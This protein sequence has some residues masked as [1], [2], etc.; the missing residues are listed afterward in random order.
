MNH[1]LSGPARGSSLSIATEADGT[2]L[3]SHRDVI[4]VR[5]LGSIVRTHRRAPESKVDGPSGA[6]ADRESRGLLVTPIVDVGAVSYLGKEMLFLDEVRGGVRN[7]EE[8]QLRYGAPTSIE[9]DAMRA[10]NT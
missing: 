10:L 3:G 5:S 2:T 8:T 9:A 4:D 6:P 1:R 7:L